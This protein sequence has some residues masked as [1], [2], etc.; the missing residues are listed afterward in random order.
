MTQWLRQR[1]IY[2]LLFLFLA[3]AVGVFW[4][5]QRQSE[6]LYQTMALQGTAL[7]AQ[8]LEDFRRIYAERVVAR[9][10]QLGI[11][12]T[13]DYATGT[14]AIP[15]PATLSMELGAEINRSTP[16]AFARLYS[17]YPFPWRKTT[18]PLD[19][20][21]RDALNALRA[22]PD[23]AFHRFEDIDGR[24]SLRYAVADRMQASCVACHNNHPDSPK[25]DWKVGDVRGVLEVI[26][27]LDRTIALY[28]ADVRWT[29]ILSMLMSG[30][31]FLGLV[32]AVIQVR[33]TSAS[34]ERAREAAVNANRAKGDFLAMMSHEI[35]TPMNGILGMTDLVLESDLTP[36]QREYLGIL[37]RST[38]TLH[39]LLND[40]LD[41]SKI[42]AGRLEL[43]SIEFDL[44]E[45]V[46][47]TLKSLGLRAQQKGLEL[48]G[49]IDPSV[50]DHVIGDPGRLRQ[51]VINLVGNAIK[52]TERGEV[53]ATVSVER[54]E[55]DALVLHF[56]VRDT[57]I[58][59]SP[60][61]QR[62]IFEAFA[63]ADSST[64]RRYGGTGLGLS[65]ATRLVE[66][67][68]G[69]LW[70]ESQPGIGSTFHFTARF[71]VPVERTVQA[72]AE[73]LAA[74]HGLRVL[75]VDDN[76][77]NRQILEQMLRNWRLQP[78]GV[79]SADSAMAELRKARAANTPFELVLLDA[80]MPDVDGFQL[81]E[82]IK[83]E[84]DL[85]GATLMMLSS[86]ASEEDA[87]RCKDLGIELYLIKPIK[88]S[89]LLDSMMN[90]IVGPAADAHAAAAQPGRQARHL[91]LA[92]DNPVNRRVAVGLLEQ[93]GH[94]VVSVN[95]GREALDALEKDSFDLVLMD[96]Q[97]PELDGLSATAELRAR[98][99]RDGGHVL[100][101]AMTAHAMAGDRE[102]CLAAGMDGYIAKP[103]QAREL[104]DL[105]DALTG[106][107]PA[108]TKR[109][110]AKASS[111][112]V[113]RFGGNEDLL[114]ELVDIFLETNPVLMVELRNAITR[115]DAAEVRRTAH[116]IKGSVGNFEAMDAHA[117]AQHLEEIG[118][119]GDLQEAAAAF[120]A[121]QDAIARLSPA[122]AGIRDG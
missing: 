15:L 25:R 96:I 109:P 103:V 120:A 117:A 33:R 116:N 21:E 76:A 34:L 85:T 55:S 20:F 39:A 67:M 14:T 72:R 19:P 105:I 110:S 43:E 75:V 57:G 86:A 49:Q 6:A 69:R 95:N 122:L 101:V 5:L 115:G 87:A 68:K 77:T 106:S 102:R 118:R 42:E 32:A 51:I 11:P 80:M 16:G 92:E 29:L 41:F 107:P 62:R 112:L 46:G 38:N 121:L 36:R 31:A 35:R 63:Q 26:R 84:S 100:V 70:L 28:R 90:L 12:A 13:H 61:Q 9:T 58:G 37:K 111:R 88:Q 1:G 47:D 93:A 4:N 45:C 81:A 104:L 18:K 83:Q 10:V 89:E 74:L 48:I 40:I 82:R 94:S 3:G 71:G 17:D 7:Q 44:R 2:L 54:I 52:F 30:L 65:I 114:R 27:P 78:V 64:T 60:E 24:P 23:S 91:L 99:A 53:V 50:P 79:D 22:Q 113:Q 59:I 98:E 56:A 108:P 97:M 73:R 66:L 8:M 119:S